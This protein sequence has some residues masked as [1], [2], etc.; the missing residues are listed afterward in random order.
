MYRLNVPNGQHMVEHLGAYPQ[1][2][3]ESLER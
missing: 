1:L 3:E 2:S